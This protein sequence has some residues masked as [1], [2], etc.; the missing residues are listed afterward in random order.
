MAASAITAQA[1]AAAVPESLRVNIEEIKGDLVALKKLG[2]SWKI[3]FSQSCTGILPVLDRMRRDLTNIVQVEAVQTKLSQIQENFDGV[4]RIYDKIAMHELVS[5][6]LYEKDFALRMLDL[7][8]KLDDVKTS[9][10]EVFAA[11]EKEKKRAS[12]KEREEE[13]VKVEEIE[14]RSKSE[15]QK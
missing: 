5:M 4:Q 7:T 9:V 6:E 12:D 10:N 15:K 2:G 14:E 3:K 11:V 1:S 13:K 8:T